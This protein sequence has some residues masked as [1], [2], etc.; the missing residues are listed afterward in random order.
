VNFYKYSFNVFVISAFFFISTCICAQN[1]KLVA[2]TGIVYGNGTNDALF[3]VTSSIPSLKFI[4]A[5]KIKGP[6]NGIFT[7][8]N[9]NIRYTAIST[10]SGIPANLSRIR[11]TFLQADKITPITPNNFRFIIN[12]IDGPDNEALATNCDAN[13]NFL[14]TA[15]PTNLTVINLPPTIIAVGSVEESDGPTSRVMFE[16]KN[17]AVIEIDN[18]ANDGY[19]K[20]FDM[21]DD[22][23]ITEPIFVKCKSYTSSIFTERS[24]KSLIDSTEFKKDNNLLLLKTNPIYFDTDKY[25]IR[26]DAAIELEKIISLLIKYPKLK[27]EIGAHTDSR[28][29]DAYNL[30]LSNNRAKSTINWML[31]KGID[32]ARISGKGYGETRLI[33]NCKNGVK[34]TY[35]EHQLNRRIEFVVKN[36]EAIKH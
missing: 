34:C 32:S 24:S 29:D 15:S 16:F 1:Y 36:P 31:N 33:N 10:A 14:G 23:P 9:D 19:L 27:I 35:K 7:Q 2:V 4:R 5:Q 30:K 3:K 26:E 25:N 6:Q 22:Y 8:Y 18:Y 28:A 13:L 12:D 20:D 11:F 17:V 21:N